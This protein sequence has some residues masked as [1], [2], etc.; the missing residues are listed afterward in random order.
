MADFFWPERADVPNDGLSER[1]V[2]DDLLRE[3]RAAYRAIA[4]C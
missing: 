2:L 4:R 1:T 3:A